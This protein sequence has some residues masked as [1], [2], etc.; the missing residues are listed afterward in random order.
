[1]V[2]WYLFHLFVSDRIR[3]NNNQDRTD[4]IKPEQ[5]DMTIS[6]PR[7]TYVQQNKFNNNLNDLIDQIEK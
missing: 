4:L 3:Y 1:M 2:N 5:Y 7:H 6:G